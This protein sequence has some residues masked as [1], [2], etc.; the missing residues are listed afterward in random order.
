MLS[1]CSSRRWLVLVFL[2]L[3]VTRRGVYAEQND[4]AA[5]AND[6]AEAQGD[7][8]A[9]QADD[10]IKYWTDYAILPKRCIV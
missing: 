10:Y 7:D 4:D 6:D 2:L 3:A 9:A 8:A 1:K 5:V